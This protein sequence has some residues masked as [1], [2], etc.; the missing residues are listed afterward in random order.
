M[1]PEGDGTFWFFCLADSD[2]A[3]QVEADARVNV[4]FADKDYLS[5]TGGATGEA[6]QPTSARAATNASTALS[7][8]SRVSAAD[9]WVRIRAF[10]FGTTG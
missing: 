6:P 10:P 3:A 9:S 2:V 5:V 1:Q 8:S 4:A 7:R